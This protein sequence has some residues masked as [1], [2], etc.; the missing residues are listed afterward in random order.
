LLSWE[1]VLYLPDDPL[2]HEWYK[3]WCWCEFPDGSS[4]NLTY[5]ARSKSIHN[6][7]V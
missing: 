3:E 7:I 5:F 6:F 2:V 4:R 1:E